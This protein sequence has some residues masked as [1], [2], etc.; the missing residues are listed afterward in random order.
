MRWSPP[1]VLI[2]EMSINTSV[3]EKFRKII[4]E[5]NKK[6]QQQEE[7][8]RRQEE[9]ARQLKHTRGRKSTPYQAERTRKTSTVGTEGTGKTGKGIGTSTQ[10]G[11]A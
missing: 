4:S 7:K 5:Q 8:V 11:T 2:K 3:Y 9:K 6:V 10:E 1:K